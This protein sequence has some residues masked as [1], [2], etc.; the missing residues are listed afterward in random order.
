MIQFSIDTICNYSHLTI[1][2]VENN[3]KM[4]RKMCAEFVV[5]VRYVCQCIQNGE[6]IETISGCKHFSKIISNILLFFANAKRTQKNILENLS[7]AHISIRAMHF[8]KCNQIVKLLN[9]KMCS[10]TMTSTFAL[11]FFLYLSVFL[12]PPHSV[13]IWAWNIGWLFLPYIKYSSC[14]T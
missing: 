10:L 2:F 4:S 1:L 9:N 5:N 12:S 8:C 7:D 3:N 11:F 13:C 14:V 6:D